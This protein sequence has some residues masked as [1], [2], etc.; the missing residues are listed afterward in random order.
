[1]SGAASKAKQK[2]EL[3]RF[4]LDGKRDTDA[5]IDK[6]MKPKTEKDKAAAAP[7]DKDKKA[8]QSSKSVGKKGKKS[9][10]RTKRHDVFPAL[11]LPAH[12]SHC[13]A[14]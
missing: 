5:L 3:N 10:V 4:R 13:T 8:G 6:Y 12:K 2:D 14:S 7:T 9:M 11:T 1:M